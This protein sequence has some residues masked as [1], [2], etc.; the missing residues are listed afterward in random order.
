MQNM[1]RGWANEITVCHHWVN[2]LLQA[3]HMSYKKG[4]VYLDKACA[5]QTLNHQFHDWSTKKRILKK[6]EGITEIQ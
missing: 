1:L 3:K 6:L 5:V 2:E 4:I